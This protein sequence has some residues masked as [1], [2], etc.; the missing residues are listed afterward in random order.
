MI[1]LVPVEGQRQKVFAFVLRVIQMFSASTPTH[2]FLMNFH[3]RTQREC[4][5][6]GGLKENPEELKNLVDSKP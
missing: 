2:T 4:K 6:G 3:R 1:D 5:L